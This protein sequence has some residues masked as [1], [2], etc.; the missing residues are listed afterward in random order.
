MTTWIRIGTGFIR[1]A[2]QLQQITITGNSL[3]LAASRIDFFWTP[4]AP[5]TAV[6]RTSFFRCVDLLRSILICQ[7]NG[8]TLE[9]CCFPK[10]KRTLPR[11]Q[12]L[13]SYAWKLAESHLGYVFSYFLRNNQTLH[14]RREN[15]KSYTLQNMISYLVKHLFIMVLSYLR[16]NHLSDWLR[17]EWLRGWS[18]SPGRM[19]N[20]DF[21]I[22]FR[23]RLGCTQPP[24]EWAPRPGPGADW[25]GKTA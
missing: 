13:T 10:R 6:T 15:L 14:S 20:C 7:T 3:A 25:I 17:A 23:P 11:M 9:A 19:K 24:I 21:S 12:L 4:A 1:S 2:L 5:S 16:K 22:S 18:S 8:L